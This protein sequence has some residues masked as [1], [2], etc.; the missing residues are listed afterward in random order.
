MALATVFHQWFLRF[1]G[2][3]VLRRCS[4][5]GCTEDTFF[6]QL[7]SS[8][9]CLP[10]YARS[11]ND[12]PRTWHWFSTLAYQFET[13]REINNYCWMRCSELFP[14]EMGLKFV[15][16]LALKLS[17]RRFAGYF[18]SLLSSFHAVRFK[19]LAL[20]RFPSTELAERTRTVLRFLAAGSN[21]K[22]RFLNYIGLP[23]LICLPGGALTWE[24]AGTV[25]GEQTPMAWN[26]HFR[27]IEG[28][29]KAEHNE[30]N[31]LILR[32]WTSN[33]SSSPVIHT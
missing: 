30:N 31:G 8:S 22:Q 15:L 29:V 2:R 27:H 3:C 28:L 20:R 10:F 25:A 32:V 18:T 17:W 26:H 21:A 11:Q 7:G 13:Q 5:A 33:I 4:T 14:C 16:L 9:R 1:R 6:Q 24:L 23:L 12:W 19:S